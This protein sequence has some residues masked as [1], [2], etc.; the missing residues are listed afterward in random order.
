MSM[1][2]NSGFSTTVVFVTIIDRGSQSRSFSSRMSAA[3]GSAAKRGLAK[4]KAIKA[5][6]HWKRLQIGLAAT[7]RLCG[8]ERGRR[9]DCQQSQRRASRRQPDVDCALVI[10]VPKSTSG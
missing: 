10:A 3:G 2:G 1:T 8:A 6:G 7:R 5:R 9:I 4:T